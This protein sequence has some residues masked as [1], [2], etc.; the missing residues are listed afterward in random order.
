LNEGQ[1]DIWPGVA[2]GVEPIATTRSYY[3][4]TYVFVT[5]GDRPLQ[6]L[7]LD[8][9]RLKSLTIGVQMIGNDAMNTPPAHA[10]ARRGITENVRGFM[11]YGDYEKPN[12]PS[13]IVDAVEKGD[14]DVAL[15]WGPLAGYFASQSR[16]PLRLE[17][18][19]PVLDDHTWP[20][21]Y[22]IAIGVRRGN[23]DLLSEIEAI[24]AKEKPSIDALLG[25]YG[26]P[27]LPNDP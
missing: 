7:T 20:M 15:V 19:T 17:P 2:T 9:A 3:R 12:P 25:I 13:L 11:I 10:L 24:L 8:D 22:S 5:R 23:P 16:V 1:C 6:G 27:L 4:S 18:V 21:T 14:V 26:V